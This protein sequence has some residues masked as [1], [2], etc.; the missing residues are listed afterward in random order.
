MLMNRMTGAALALGL[1]AALTLSACAGGGGAGEDGNVVP[2]GVPANCNFGP[3]DDAEWVG[4]LNAGVSEGQVNFYHVYSPGQNTNVFDAFREV[5]PG[6]TI[7]ETAGGGANL[8]Q[9]DSELANGT[10][11]ADVFMWGD[12]EWFKANEEY[13]VE[14]EGPF[15]ET[16][17]ESEWL[18]DGKTINTYTNPLGFL[19]WN[20]EE[21]PDGFESFTELTDPALAGRIGMREDITTSFIGTLKHLSDEFGDDFLRDLGEQG[22]KFYPSAFVIPQAIAAGEIGVAPTGTVASVKQLVD[23]GAPI[24]YS[25]KDSFSVPMPA[26]IIST[27]EHTAAA[28]VFMQW[29]MSEDGQTALV[30]GYGQGAFPTED[31]LDLTGTTLFDAATIT[32]DVRAEWEA[33]FGEYFR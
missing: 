32:P 13:L 10:P 12:S 29:L 28:Q 2:A 1:L 4:Q 19:I 5:C 3:T 8:A 27:G 14:I 15:N 23:Q 20:T 25:L 7:Q 16:W 17:P 11:G 26:S 31:A 9:M 30:A 33:K 24:A 18:I 6:I 21:F 22:L